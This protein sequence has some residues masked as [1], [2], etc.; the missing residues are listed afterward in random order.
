MACSVIE[1]QIHDEG[2]GR[3][4]EVEQEFMGVHVS[5]FA[6]MQSVFSGMGM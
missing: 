3:V 5:R 4:E 2:L 6:A 1:A